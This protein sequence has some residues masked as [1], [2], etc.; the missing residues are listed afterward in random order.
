MLVAPL[1]TSAVVLLAA[2]ISGQA[3]GPTGHR[4]LPLDTRVKRLD[5]HSLS[6]IEAPP[7][8]DIGGEERCERP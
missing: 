2:R 8:E 1:R 4:G 5:R 6:I 7:P 3:D